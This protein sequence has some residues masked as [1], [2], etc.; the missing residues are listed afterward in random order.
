LARFRNI[1]YSAGALFALIHD[2]IFIIG[3][4]SLLYKIMPFSMEIDQSFIAAILT[5]VGY[6]INDKVVVFDR[7]REMV[8]L[9]PKRDRGEI[10][11]EAVNATLIR[12]LSTSL[13]TA[14]VLVV[15]LLLGGET[16]RGFVF[17]MLL[18]VIVG[19]YSTIFVAVP[20][21]YDSFQ[22]SEAKKL[23]K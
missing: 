22:K 23:K 4:Y 18:G 14:L 6:S 20:M 3:A 12:T 2:V 15:I 19:T 1:S 7:V 5:I 17:A 13:S 21:A 9:Y 11:N 8:N 10:I 16:I